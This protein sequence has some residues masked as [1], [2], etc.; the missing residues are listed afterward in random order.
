MKSLLLF[1]IIFLICYLFYIVFVLCRKNVLKKFINS[2]EIVYLKYKYDI[3]VNDK[4]IKKIANAI[5]IG[6]SFILSLTVSIIS[7]FDNFI[8]EILIGFVLVFVLI[9]LVYYIIGNLF[10]GGKKNV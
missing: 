3:K 1:L 2:K 6:N 4:N 10:K 7:L 8:V 9:F 5:F